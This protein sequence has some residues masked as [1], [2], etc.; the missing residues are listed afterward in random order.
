[1]NFKGLFWFLPAILFSLTGSAQPPAGYYNTAGNLTGIALKQALHGIID[2]HAVVP[3]SDLMGYFR[4]T[5]VKNDSL[6]WDMYSDNPGGAALYTY[7]FGKGQECGNYNSEADCYNREHSFPKSWFNNASPMYSDLFHIYPTDG[8]VNNRRGN[9]PYGETE[10]PTWTSQN[11]SKVGPCSAAGYSGIVFEPI[12]EYKGDFARTIFYMAARYYTQDNGWPGSDMVTG[13]EPK[14]WAAGLL[15]DWHRIDPVSPKEILRNN[16]VFNIQKNRNPFIDDSDYAVKIWGRSS[17]TGKFSSAGTR[18]QVYPNPASDYFRLA[19]D[20]IE[21]C[22]LLIYNQEG[23][24]LLQ[25]PDFN[26]TEKIDVRS[27]PGGLYLIRII[28]SGETRTGLFI[29]K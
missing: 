18:L 16:E 24:L 3:Y 8:Y 29:R 19:F 6:V 4:K 5:D 28:S 21:K 14:P 12:D 10:S 9:Y 2:N 25:Y 17:H 13:A 26:T 7:K 23:I 22:E 1:M 15:L 20:L 11:G 27:L